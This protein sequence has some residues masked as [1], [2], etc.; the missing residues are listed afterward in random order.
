MATLFRSSESWSSGKESA[1][2][3]NGFGILEK[4]MNCILHKITLCTLL[5]AYPQIYVPSFQYFTSFI[6]CM[7]WTLYFSILFNVPRTLPID[8]VYSKLAAL[9]VLTSAYHLYFSLQICTYWVEILHFK[10]KNNNKSTVG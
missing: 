10:T 7:T 9:N 1:Y 4:A 3:R 6:S 8:N 2:G 5:I